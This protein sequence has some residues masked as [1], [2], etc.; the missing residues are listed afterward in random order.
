MEIKF[1][2]NIIPYIFIGPH[3]LGLFLFTL[4]PLIMSLIM[5]FFNWPVIGERVFTG[6]SNYIELFTKDTQF[7]KSLFIT[8]KFTV[9][10]VPVNIVLS[11]LL[12]LLISQDLKG[13]S[14]FR[15]IFYLPTVVSSVAISIIWGW[16]LNGEYGILNYFLS[17]LKITGPDWL[18]SEKYSIFALII[19]SGWTVGVMMLVFYTAL[20]SIP[21]EL[22]ES[23]IIDGAN[24]IV[25]FFKITLPLI[26]PTLLFN[27]VTAIIGALQNLALVILLTNGGPLNSTYMY[28]LFVYNNAFKK[29]RLGYASASAW[30]MFIFILI[31]TGVIFKSSKKWVYN[32][33][34]KE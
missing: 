27:L 17:I 12:A 16:I 24:N 1:K 15:I 7:Y 20:K 21:Y 34:N 29:S 23:A 19:A 8:F 13:M 30:V 28:G 14:F 3:F 33:D 6:F 9:I 22:Y 25:I 26:T 4:G 2:K 11:L 18:N 32:Y 10:F 31:I 5:S